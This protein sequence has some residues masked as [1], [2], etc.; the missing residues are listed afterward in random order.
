VS[1]PGACS[2]RQVSGSAAG[3]RQALREESSARPGG[4][5]RAAAL[6]GHRRFVQSQRH[7]D[8]SPEEHDTWRQLVARTRESVD[9]YENRLHPDY[10]AGFRRWVQPC[11]E[12][13][14]LEQISA[15]LA[16]IGWRALCVN[17]YLP[18]DIYSALLSRGIFPVSREIRRPEH[19][20]FS[21]V[22][23][24]AHDLIGHVPMLASLEHRHFLQRLSRAIST[25][26]YSR[27]DRQLYTAQHAMA[28]LLCAPSPD[29]GAIAAADARVERAQVA[30]AA[31][32]SL[33]ARLDRLYLWS[34]EFGLLGTRDDFR[35]YGAGLMSSP[36][37]TRAL[38]SGGARILPFSDAVTERS[39]EFSEHQS[40]YYVARDHAELEAVLSRLLGT[41]EPDTDLDIGTDTDLG[42]GTDTDL[43][44]GID[45]DN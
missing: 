5:G 22:P 21:P 24:L 31:Q 12:I 45:T 41:R 25:T 29:P 9:R 17:G 20:D 43:G 33:L 37:E 1:L 35:A 11:S 28:A 13:P 42:I 27:R 8:Y 4:S 36:A 26:R 39:I 32:P 15:M 19:L 6:A 7:E 2:P 3:R 30:I 14:D 16:H 23:D 38:C 44:I 34:I 40:V 10:V 18:A